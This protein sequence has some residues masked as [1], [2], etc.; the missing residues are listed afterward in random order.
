MPKK[1]AHSLRIN[2]TTTATVAI[3]GSELEVFLCCVENKLLS[4][5]ENNNK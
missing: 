5:I 2:T 3:F 1:R 4:F